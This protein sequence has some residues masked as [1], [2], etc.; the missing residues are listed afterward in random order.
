M[1]GGFSSAVLLFYETLNLA[2]M[3]I[4]LFLMVFGWVVIGLLIE[5]KI[6]FMIRKN[7][8]FL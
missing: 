5:R 3:S 7:R 6:H 8:E 4:S 2:K 1:I